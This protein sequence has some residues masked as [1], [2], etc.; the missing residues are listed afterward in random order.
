[1]IFLVLLLSFLFQIC[2]CGNIDVGVGIWD[3]TGPSVDINFMGY[4]LPSQRGTGIH[5]RLR[6]R[7]FVFRSVSEDA[8]GKEKFVAFVSI[9]GG[10]ASDL[11]KMKTVDR[12]REKL[13]EDIYTTENFGLSGTHTHSGPAGFLQYVLFQVTSFGFVHETFDSLVEGIASSVVM[14][15]NNL[16]KADILLSQGKLFDANINRSP[17]SYL[18]NPQAEQDKYKDQGDTD[19]NMLLLQFLGDANKLKAGAFAGGSKQ[20]LGVLNWFAVHG[21]SMNNTNT[22]IS[23]DNRGYASYLMERKMNGPNVQTGLGPFVAAFASSNLGDV[24]PNT[25]GAK[26]IDTGEPCDG[27]TSSCNG[28]CENCIAFGPGENGDNFE[29]CEIIGRKQ[30]DHAISLLKSNEQ[31]VVDG[32]VDFRHSFVDFSELIVN[33]TTADGQ[34]EEV[35]LCSPAMGYA[36]A[37]GTTDGPGAFGFTQ[38]TTTGNPFWDKV[39]GLL[40]VPTQEEIDCQ[41]PKPILL[42]TGDV[43]RPYE[44]DPKILPLQI[45]RVGSVFILNVPC[46]FTTMAGRRLREAIHDVL[47]ANLPAEETEGE[48]FVTIA[49]LS[50]SYAS[51]TVTYEE[52]QAQRYEA[53]STIFGPHALEG[54]IQEFS[55]LAMD[56]ARGRPSATG[57]STPDL[58][59]KQLELVREP[60]FDSCP[61]DW[62]LG[63]TRGGSR[64]LCFGEVVA[65]KDAKEVYTRGQVVQ[66]SFYGASPRN[67]NRPQDTYMTVERIV[68]GQEQNTVVAWDGDWHTTF[69]WT[70]IRESESESHVEF[71]M[72]RDRS[73]VG[74]KGTSTS[75]E[76]QATLAFTIPDEWPAGTYRMCYFGDH[77]L[78]G[79]KGKT[80][81][82]TGCTSNFQIQA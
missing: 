70:K 9:D 66:A 33:I 6:S 22:L 47:K 38:G 31:T 29:S 65:G 1:M 10:M 79:N 82:F 36:F 52:Y 67:N 80:V 37:A 55:R 41:H 35:K 42:N 26:C 4:A 46:E 77:K 21:T 28:R 40:S 57:P 14:A 50:N 45:L 51:Y 53:A 30:Y 12:I 15:H 68:E 43:D 60:K 72:A 75:T 5:Q 13:G 54:Y 64:A 25:D 39:S 49:G 48:I 20:L 74:L 73:S 44:W 62:P 61:E 27:L 78:R 3:I 32:V 76:S 63:L 8:N 69:T 81:P 71:V 24:S 7:A 59:D 17:T 19:K 58:S 16:Q 18:L 34:Q 2:S 23:G 56:M 11:V